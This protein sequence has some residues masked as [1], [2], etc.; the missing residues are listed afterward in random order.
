MTAPLSVIILNFNT[1]D[2]TLA[3]LK[4][5][6]AF[7]QD[8]GWQLL[9][10]DNGSSDGSVEAIEQAF[11]NIELIAS[12][13]NRGY[14]G[15]NNLGL[16]HAHGDNII[17]LNSDVLAEPSVLKALAGYLSSH[18]DVGAVSP[19]LLTQAGVAQPYAFGCD[20]SLGYLLR[21]GFCSLVLRRS[22]HDW[23]VA[24]PTD[25]NWIS[26]ACFCVRRSV[27]TQVGLLDDRFFL[28]FEDNEWCMRMRAAGW[29][30]V[31][32]PSWSVVHLGGASQTRGRG[33]PQL[34][35]DS[36]LYL[37]QKHYPWLHTLILRI[38]LAVYRRLAAVRK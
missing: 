8:E 19:R 12:P 34:Y 2:L 28:Y 23:G 21:R 18:P 16:K 30:I 13:T 37:Y 36:L 3:C 26:G 6:S 11:P 32:N 14:A 27:V 33:S 10:V 1:R 31:Y 29:R 17:L 22:V 24:H 15:G 5:L 7:A 35:Y 25:V 4:T 38:T 20:P 9:V